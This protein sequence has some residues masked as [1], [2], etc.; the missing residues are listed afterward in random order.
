MKTFNYFSVLRTPFAP[1]RGALLTATL[2]AGLPGAA[3]AQVPDA[4]QV[5]REQPQPSATRPPPLAPAP[6]PPAAATQAA[7]AGPA[8]TLRRLDIQGNRQMDDAALQALVQDAYG[9]TVT[10][11]E[12]QALADRMTRH[13]QQAGY[14]L[15]FAW[16]PA[17]TI[18]EG[19]VQVQ[20]LEGRI[21]DKALTNTS[22]VDTALLEGV[23]A[24]IRSGEIARD[25]DQER[26]L[27]LLNE[28]PGV[29]A[30]RMRLEPGARHGGTRLQ[31]DVEGAPQV[32]WRA[33]ADNHG[34]PYSGRERLGMEVAANNLLGRADEL[35]GL[36]AV[37]RE[38]TV[39][40]QADDGLE[41]PAVAQ[42]PA[43]R[44]GGGGQPLQAGQHVCRSGRAR[45]RVHAGRAGQL[46]AGA[47]PPAQRH[48]ARRA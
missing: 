17:Q 7:Q 26:A 34:N 29:G 47:Q 45:P 21:D 27:V 48:A 28:L 33:F 15:A 43:R 40:A 18:S 20:V 2:L 11:A 16:V 6:E 22:R 1:A 41:R 5:L 37:T 25:A 31:V 36:L 46:S 3:L 23:L 32:R 19:V 30:A 12:V 42:R 35:S 24:P 9:Q 8:F 38:G 44:P 14:A 4:G 39:S 13:Y 10:L